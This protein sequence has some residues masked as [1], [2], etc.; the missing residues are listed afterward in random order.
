MHSI[1]KNNYKFKLLDIG[2]YFFIIGLFF[3]PSALSISIVFLLISSII[4]VIYQKKNFLKEG[5]IN[6]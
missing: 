3:L 6:L 2:T 1:L 5:L 4:S